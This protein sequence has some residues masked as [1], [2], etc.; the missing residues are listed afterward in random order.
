MQHEVP[1]TACPFSAWS[2]LVQVLLRYGLRSQLQS[3]L[4]DVSLRADAAD[5][6]NFL[7]RVK[8]LLLDLDVMDDG[9]A[10]KVLHTRSKFREVYGLEPGPLQLQIQG[11]LRLPLRH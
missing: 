7:K 8:R 2:V 4:L 6:R 3:A 5:N 11:Q 9:T 1:K 10:A